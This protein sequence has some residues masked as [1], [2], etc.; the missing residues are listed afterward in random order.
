MSCVMPPPAAYPSP[1]RASPN[2]VGSSSKHLPR[3][4]LLSVPTASSPVQATF[5]SHLFLVSSP[6]IHSLQSSYTLLFLKKSDVI[7]LPKVLWFLVALRIYQILSPG[8]QDLWS[9]FPLT[10][11]VLANSTLSPSKFWSHQSCY[12]LPQGLGMCYPLTASN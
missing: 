4:C 8:S 5:I 12:Q 7:L 3:V 2:P 9:L 6:P 10:S 11:S 1:L